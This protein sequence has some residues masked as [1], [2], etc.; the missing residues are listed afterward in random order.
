MHSISDQAL[1]TA[2]QHELLTVDFRASGIDPAQFGFFDQ[3]AF[4]AREHSNVDYPTNYAEWVLTRPISADYAAHVTATVPRLAQLLASAFADR[5]AWGCCVQ[6]SN[7][8]MRM[9]D[10]LHVWSFCI[11]G[12]V[13]IEAPALG[14]RRA[15][16]T[17]ASKAALR[18]LSAIHGYARRPS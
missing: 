13:M 7:M 14:L 4:L 8:M 17:V 2:R 11:F 3:P 1:R 18:I 12:S 10:L 16:Q 6:A 5:G 15:I 9:L